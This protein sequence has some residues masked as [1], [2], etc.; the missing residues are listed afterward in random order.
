MRYFKNLVFISEEE[1]FYNLTEISEIT[2]DFAQNVLNAKGLEEKG[3]K[4]LEL[5][6]VIWF[7]N[8]E[9]E[10]FPARGTKLHFDY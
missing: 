10:T 5:I 6:I 4:P 3:F 9:I 2:C 1:I 8:G 7:E